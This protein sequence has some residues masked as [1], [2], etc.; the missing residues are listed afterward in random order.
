MTH[1]PPRTVRR[2]LYF[3]LGLYGF[4]W[5]LVTAR[6]LRTAGVPSAPS[7]GQ[8]VTWF[9][10]FALT[11]VIAV[12]AFRNLWLITGDLT[13]SLSVT[14]H[15][16]ALPLLGVLY[17]CLRTRRAVYDYLEETPSLRREWVEGPGKLRCPVVYWQERLNARRDAPREKED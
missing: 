8:W 13:F 14:G 9:L 3:S 4:Y 5:I 6:E 1:R 12:V 15:L 2:R 7:R 10:L 16:V 11:P 17:A